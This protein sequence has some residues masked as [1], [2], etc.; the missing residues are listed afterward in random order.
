MILESR[1]KYPDGNPI[2]NGDMFE[3]KDGNVGFIFYD[4]RNGIWNVKFR[5]KGNKDF[6]QSLESLHR[7]IARFII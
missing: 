5:S 2:H 4:D 1:F 3:F 6:V 7:W